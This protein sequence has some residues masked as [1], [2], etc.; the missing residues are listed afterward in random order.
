MVLSQS[1]PNSF[2]LKLP[3]DSRIHD[4]F[5]VSRLKPH[6]DPDMYRRRKNPLPTML[7]GE[8]QYEI[9]RIVDHDHKFGVQW[10]KIAWKGWSEVYYSTWEPREELMKNASKLVER[11]EKE[12]GLTDSQPIKR[13]PKK[14]S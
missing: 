2:R 7:R 6:T 3:E 5:H 13:K 8:E 9:E 10:F 4:I 1:G 12:H 11:Y 14:R